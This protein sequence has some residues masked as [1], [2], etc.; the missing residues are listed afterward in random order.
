MVYLF[1]SGFFFFL[2]EQ[3]EKLK[4]LLYVNPYL[5]PFIYYLFVYLFTYKMPAS[6]LS[7]VIFVISSVERN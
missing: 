1:L 4:A 3:I 7:I 6:A 2:T 5:F